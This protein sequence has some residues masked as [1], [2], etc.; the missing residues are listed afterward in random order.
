MSATGW[1][2]LRPCRIKT[3]D[4]T[5]FCGSGLYS[6]LG[7]IL[8]DG[9]SIHNRWRDFNCFSWSILSPTSATRRYRIGPWGVKTVDFTDFC[10]RCL[11]RH[12]NPGGIYLR[13]D[14]SITAPRITILVP[15]ACWARCLLHA[16]IG[17]VSVTSKPRI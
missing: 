10:G 4:V 6:N 5:Y 16:G 9:R 17:W 11:Y 3:Q 2:K 13:A 8:L 1:F 7:T 15:E 14:S 12:L